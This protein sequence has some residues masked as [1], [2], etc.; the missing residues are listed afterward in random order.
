MSALPVFLASPDDEWADT[1]EPERAE[2]WQI[3]GTETA[4]WA[5][6]KVAAAHADLDELKRQAA[7]WKQRVDEWLEHESAPLVRRIEFFSGHLERYALDV[8]EADPKKKSLVLPSGVVKTRVSN[9]RVE[10]VD[11][12][13]FVEWAAVNAPDAVRVVR[14]P[15]VSAL[16]WEDRDGVPVAD[17]GEII[18]GLAV[19][20]AH[21][22][23]KVEVAS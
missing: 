14:K 1:L 5:M 16:A 17:G 15:L 22:T 13:A 12:E 19:V 23:A 3:T 18:P 11:D 8:R 4:A 2:R 20:P 21:V 7:E 6:G 9:P 10:V